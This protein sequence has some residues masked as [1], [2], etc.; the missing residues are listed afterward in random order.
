MSMKDKGPGSRKALINEEANRIREQH[1]G[2]GDVMDRI[3]EYLEIY[4]RDIGS[5]GPDGFFMVSAITACV[6]CA[7]LNEPERMMDRFLG[8]LDEVF[9][10]IRESSCILVG[11]K[12]PYVLGVPMSTDEAVVDDHLASALVRLDDMLEIYPPYGTFREGSSIEIRD[13][14][15]SGIVYSCLRSNDPDSAL[16]EVHRFCISVY[17]RIREYVRLNRCLPK[18]DRYEIAVHG[19]A[20]PMY[21]PPNLE[22][23]MDILTDLVYEGYAPA[24]YTMGQMC[25]RGEYFE[26]DMK[27]GVQLIIESAEKGCHEAYYPASKELRSGKYVEKDVRLADEY[28]TK[29]IVEHDLEAIVEHYN[30]VGCISKDSVRELVSFV[31]EVLK[32]PKAAETIVSDRSVASVRS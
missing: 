26:H 29:A 11:R 24:M 5:H 14:T 19:K 4:D 9:G 28:E 30:R 32:N 27:R 10:T 20:G 15:L 31:G 1:P 7:G 18:E 21:S 13:V 12:R 16:A 17:D 25:I 3:S 2:A 23:R 6:Y 8:L 22:S